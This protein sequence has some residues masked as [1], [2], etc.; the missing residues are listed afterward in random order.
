M[1]VLTGCTRAEK[2]RYQKTYLGLFDTVITIL[3][4][5]E[6]E[7]AFS[8]TTETIYKELDACNRLYD[9][10]E[11]YPDLVNLCTINRHPGETLEVDQR[12]IDL[13]L[14]A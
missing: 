5:E 2:K 3:G 1:L 12:I 8:R 7:E 6:S 11:E 10:Y 9:I 13:L 4:Y 14:F